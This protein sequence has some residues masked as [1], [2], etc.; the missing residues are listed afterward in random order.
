MKKYHV[1]IL[2]LLVALGMPAVA[3]ELQPTPSADTAKVAS[4]EQAEAVA[5]KVE[6]AERVNLNT[7]DMA[8]LEQLHGVGPKTA[9]A[10]MDFRDAQGEFTSPDQL[11][12]IKGIGEKTLAKM[13]NQIVVQ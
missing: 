12:A 1:A 6:S 3:V 7:A 10:I 8:E 9:Q 4:A 11:L 2:P 5:A 13:R